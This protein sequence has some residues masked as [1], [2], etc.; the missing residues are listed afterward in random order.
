M[1][2]LCDSRGLVSKIIVKN[3]EEKSEFWQNYGLNAFACFVERQ[4]DNLIFFI[5]FHS[6]SVDYD[7]A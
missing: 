7:L 2:I 4:G 6:K 5:R 3:G 1:G